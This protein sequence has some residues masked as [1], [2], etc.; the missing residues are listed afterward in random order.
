MSD[1]RIE[2]GWVD[3]FFGTL[4]DGAG[5]FRRANGIVDAGDKFVYNGTTYKL[6]D[7][8]VS[9]LGDF[10]KRITR[11]DDV[12]FVRGASQAVEY[13]VYKKG[14]V[15]QIHDRPSKKNIYEHEE[16]ETPQDSAFDRYF[17][18]NL[19]VFLQ[20]C[21]IDRA[22]GF[23]S[24]YEGL[25]TSAQVYAS[26]LASYRQ[27][28]RAFL[29][30]SNPSENDVKG[31]LAKTTTYNSKAQIYQGAKTQFYSYSV[32]TTSKCEAPD[33]ADFQNR[34]DQVKQAVVDVCDLNGVRN[35]RSFYEALLPKA[36][37]YAEE[38]ESYR[39][40]VSEYYK[41]VKPTREQ[42]EAFR[43][44]KAR[45]DEVA[46]AYHNAR[47]QFYSI[48]ASGKAEIPDFSGFQSHY[49][50]MSRAVV[51]AL[52]LTAA[53]NLHSSH[54]ALLP[55]AREYGPVVK[56]YREALAA[57]FDISNPT[58]TDLDRLQQQN[59]EY[60]QISDVYH[61]VKNQFYSVQTKTSERIEPP[62]FSA[63]RSYYDQTK[64]LIVDSFDLLGAI[65]FRS[66]Y[67]ALVAH[68]KQY[69]PEARNYAEALRVYLKTE[70][71]TQEQLQ[72]LQNK[73]TRLE[74]L[75]RTYIDARHVFYSLVVVQQGFKI[76]D[77]QSYFQQEY[78]KKSDKIVQAHDANAA[79]DLKARYNSLQRST[80][81]Y[82][83]ELTNY[84]N[85]LDAYLDLSRRVTSYEVEIL[86]RQKSSC[87]NGSS[88]YRSARDAFFSIRNPNQSFEKPD[89]TSFKGE[90]ERKIDEFDR[91]C[92][93]QKKQDLTVLYD[94]LLRSAR[95]YED[96]ANDFKRDLR[97][98][99]Q[100]EN[101]NDGDLRSIR[102][103]QSQFQ[104]VATVYGN[105]KQAFDNYSRS[106]SSDQC[107]PPPPSQP[108]PIP[109]SEPHPIPDDD[110]NNPDEVDDI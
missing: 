50:Q 27:D 8:D 71:P 6:S 73:K 2:K 38:S 84:R 76:P 9:D 11:A 58:Q 25:K 96:D 32:R 22:Q 57:Y 85:G 79:V 75:A 102:R 16:F 105:D 80:Q 110:G 91:N 47:N 55:V 70:L 65:N 100:K 83:T 20:G 14:G 26:Q 3:P 34:Y 68:A 39:Q 4:K 82:S 62:D 98:F 30:N 42:V 48:Q 12:D 24:L 99:L 23:R 64:R 56:K 78:E 69:D 45:Y 40:D 109:P 95:R 87:Q 46:R 66:S 103:R 61:N 67:E 81:F 36:Q 74:Q 89:Y 15:I 37:Q 29:A 18:D 13:L 41:I 53:M 35:I 101:T 49:D 93:V 88:E 7:A 72:V 52:D 108:R 86:T 51:D 92:E 106:G 1:M 77:S 19:T 54:Q 43:V 94:N 31:F 90:Y 28:Q 59:A 44:Q 17:R 60:E 21:D 5:L 63:F 33:F 104:D 107:A 10:F 97:S